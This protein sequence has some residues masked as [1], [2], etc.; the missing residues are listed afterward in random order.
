MNFE[1]LIDTIKGKLYERLS[2]PILFSYSIFFITFNWR[3]FYKLIQG[4]SL[5]SIDQF[6]INNSFEITKPAIYSLIYVIL[7]PI[8]KLISEPYSEFIKTLTLASRNYF[9]KNWQEQDMATI[10]EIEKNI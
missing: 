8:L 6:L 3:F 1:E 2:N 5:S 7:T 4:D 9:R 10:S